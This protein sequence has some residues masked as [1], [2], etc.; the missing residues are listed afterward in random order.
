MEPLLTEQATLNGENRMSEK[1]DVTVLG[2]SIP[3][4]I[5][6]A[7]VF[8]GLCSCVYSAWIVAGIFTRMESQQAVM[9]A[10]IE[11]IK[12]ELVT[13]N[14]FESRVQLVNSAIERNREDI[15]RH[16]ERLARLEDNQH[17]FHEK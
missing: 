7:T 17:R 8:A 1:D 13:K 6:I 12:A 3:R 10:N 4:S 16:E 11:Q 9:A 14:E 2:L 15:R 5:G